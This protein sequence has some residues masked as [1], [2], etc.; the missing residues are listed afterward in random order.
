[1]K[2]VT[3][4]MKYWAVLALTVMTSPV[5]ALGTDAGVSIENTA[6]AAFSVNGVVQTP[7]SSNTVATIV[8]ELI[9]VV[10]V[11]DV[12]G[13]LLVASGAA[14]TVRQFSVTNNGNGDEVFR[15]IVDDA[16]AE[17]GFDPQ[18]SALYIESN[19]LAGLQVGSDTPYI[20]GVS[21]PL[22]AEDDTLVLYVVADIPG[23]LSQGD[24]G[25][26][27]VRAVADTIISA[28]SGID[29]PD[30]PA[31]PVPGTSYIGLGDGGGTAVVGT[32]H[33]P[34][35]LLMRTTGRYEV[36][37][38]VVNIS[39]TAISV[40]DPFGG[41]TIV[42]GTVITYQLTVSVS[43]TGTAQSLVITDPIPAELEYQL[44]TLLVD[45]AAEDDDFEPAGTDVA[46]FDA[47]TTTIQVDRGD[48]TGGSAP[49]VI[50]FE[51][52]IR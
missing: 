19:G 38:A 40:V 22:L 41:S 34:S 8:D 10:V 16:I 9:D 51:A 4:M 26:V 18:V 48:V 50:T 30:N 52:A 46:G 35:N 37:D 7:I 17:G 43:G 47:G 5:F 12:G 14:D 21:D 32:S 20:S 49:V 45:G 44:G 28:T 2:A 11:D 13:T 39:K 3:N 36:S 31:W 24:F 33:D 15:L 27:S 23:G 42:P 25:D 1:M 6:S 29:D